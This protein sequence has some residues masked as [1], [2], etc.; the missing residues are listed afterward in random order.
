MIAEDHAWSIFVS[1][2]G[3]RNAKVDHLHNS[4]GSYRYAGEIAIF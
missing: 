2:A 3:M 1:S 4:V